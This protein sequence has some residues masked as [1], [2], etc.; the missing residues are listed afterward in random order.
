LGIGASTAIFSVV[1][2]VLM[3]PLPYRDPDRL[4]SLSEEHLSMPGVDRLSFAT[5]RDLFQRSAVI[6]D[7]LYYTDGGGGRLIEN[8]E[9]EVL[10]G[11]RVTAN[12]FHVLGI[13]A[14]IGRTFAADDVCL[15]AVMSSF[16]LMR[17]GRRG[18]GAI[19]T[20]STACC[21]YPTGSF[22]SSV[23]SGGLSSNAY[24][25]PGRDTSSV[26]AI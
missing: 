9:A 8:G 4:V 18:L 12:F 13:R 7:I 21:T 14:E 1:H 11:Q 17:F 15:A 5:G 23:S 2:A 26:S 20:S 10:R 19:P 25:E 22:A 24:V 6:E 16:C 3:K